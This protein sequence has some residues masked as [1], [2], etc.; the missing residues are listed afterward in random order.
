MD[1]LNTNDNK[2][3]NYWFAAT[4]SGPR[5]SLLPLS[6]PS[7]FEAS[8]LMALGS[9]RNLLEGDGISLTAISRV[10]GMESTPEGDRQILDALLQLKRIIPA[11]AGLW[12]SKSD[13]L[14]RTGDDVH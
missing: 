2:P 3:P 5:P 9:Q 14:V 12:Y 10:L 7:K 1:N 11:L 6:T 4:T 8:V 13:G